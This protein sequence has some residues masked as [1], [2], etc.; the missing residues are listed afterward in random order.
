MNSILKQWRKI[1]VFVLLLALTMSCNESHEIDDIVV[2][3]DI[4]FATAHLKNIG[5]AILKDSRKDQVAELI[6]A[7][8]SKRSDGETSVIIEHLFESSEMRISHN[9]ET[10]SADISESLNAFK[11]IEGVD[12]YPQIYIPYYE[13]AIARRNQSDSGLPVLVFFVIDGETEEYPGYQLNEEGELV[14]LNYLIDEEYARNN[15]VWVI[16]LSE[17]YFGGSESSRSGLRELLG[18]SAKVDR[19]KVKQHKESWAAGASEVHILSILSDFDF[20]NGTYFNYGGG[21]NE[22]GRIKKVNRSDINKWKGTDFKVVNNWD[23]WGTLT[24]SNYV[25]FEYDTWPT[26]KK[27]ATFLHQALG[28]QSEIEYRS[29][30]SFYDRETITKTDW[31]QVIDIVTDGIRWEPSYE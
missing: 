23:S 22:G 21:I 18:E 1:R 27:K 20:Y 10:R 25:I 30:H 15:E 6:Y 31:P 2:Q 7:N 19:I 5:A 12:Y 14:E 9:L 4:A 26:G 24:Y 16:S 17:S 29:G 11:G 13:E 8:V 28:F 3:D